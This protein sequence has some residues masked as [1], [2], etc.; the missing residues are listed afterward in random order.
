MTELKLA[1]DVK[2]ELEILEIVN[3]FNVQVLRTAI[4]D[5]VL[6]PL[7]LDAES[8][9]A[10]ADP[11]K[12]LANMRSWL[13][14]LDLAITPAFIREALTANIDQDLAEALLRYFVRKKSHST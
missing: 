11:K 13:K 8:L 6:I 2:F 4:Q 5:E 1:A 9:R 14:L 10:P 3:G 7:G 12:T